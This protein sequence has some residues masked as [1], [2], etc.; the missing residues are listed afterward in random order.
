MKY[1]NLTPHAINIVGEN[2]EKIKTIKPSGVQARVAVKTEPIKTLDDGIQV[3]KSTYGAVEGLPEP[4][5]KTI[6]IVSMMVAS[7]VPEERCDVVVPYGYVRD[8]NG[9]IIGCRGF[10]NV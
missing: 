9:N 8:E 1:V 5:L 4:E 3:Y 6:Y 10:Q 7:R 2:G